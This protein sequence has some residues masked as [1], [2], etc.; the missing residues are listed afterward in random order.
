M[1]DIK[2]LTNRQGFEENYHLVLFEC[3]DYG[4]NCEEILEVLNVILNSS[5]KQSQ[6]GKLINL[7]TPR[8][9]INMNI[10]VKIISCLNYSKVGDGVKKKL[11]SWLLNNMVLIDYSH[12]VDKLVPWIWNLLKVGAIR[13]K[14]VAVLV[15]WINRLDDI[16]ELLFCKYK[17]DMI[18]SIYKVDQRIGPL[19]WS[20]RHLINDGEEIQVKKK[21]KGIDERLI[22]KQGR[23]FDDND[24]YLSNLKVYQTMNGTN[25]WNGLNQY[26]KSLSSSNIN[27]IKYIKGLEFDLKEEKEEG[28]WDPT[29]LDVLDLVLVVDQVEL[30][31]IF[32]VLLGYD[33]GLV[34]FKGFMNEI[35]SKL[36]IC[37]QVGHR[38][39]QVIVGIITGEVKINTI[40]K[41]DI[42]TLR[43]ISAHNWLEYLPVSTSVESLIEIIITTRDEEM[44]FALIRMGIRWIEGDFSAAEGI[45]KKI[46]RIPRGI[47]SRFGLQLE[48]LQKLITDKKNKNESSS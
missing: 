43:E 34:V 41:L 23:F 40:T 9:L 2:L 38:L 33:N 8:E 13:E 10:L 47:N 45:Y 19:I 4:L 6:K 17:L 42:K 35:L 25:K 48:K 11:S 22:E 39:P 5:L 12:G 7:L 26:V 16:N 20:L 36:S 32:N 28:V 29:M 3:D 46:E 30:D 21:F 14:I 27:V 44:I 31:Y 24:Q 37:C 1:V 15:Y 18:M